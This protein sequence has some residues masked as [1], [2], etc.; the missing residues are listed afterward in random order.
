M[1]NYILSD[2]LTTNVLQTHHSLHHV[3]CHA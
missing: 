1:R 2:G 3:W